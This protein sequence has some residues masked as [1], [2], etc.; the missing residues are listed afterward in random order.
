MNEKCKYCID[1]YICLMRKEIGTLYF[2]NLVGL[3][4]CLGFK[5]KWWYF[6]KKL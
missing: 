6:W 2:Y 4:F 3:K 1:E 5:K